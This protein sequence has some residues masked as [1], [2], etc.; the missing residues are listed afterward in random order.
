MDSILWESDFPHPTC[1]YPDS[2]KY[3]EA[4]MKDWTPA[5]RQQ[6]LVDNAVKVFNLTN[7]S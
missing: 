4:A 2:Q 6:I 5:E 7:G 1:T 3:I